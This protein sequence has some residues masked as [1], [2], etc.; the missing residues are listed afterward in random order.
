V[1]TS[2]TPYFVLTISVCLQWIPQQNDHGWTKFL[3]YLAFFLI[4]YIIPMEKHF[5]ED[6]KKCGWLALLLGIITFSVEGLLVFKVGY[7]PTE[8]SSLSW[9][10]V[11]FQ[12]AVS[13]GSI[14]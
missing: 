2:C 10:Y 4:G 8:V 3:S 13:L 1:Q 9:T 7:D 14:S 6:I 5:F 12:L 11:C